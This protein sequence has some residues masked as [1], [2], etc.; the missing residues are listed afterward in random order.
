M[1]VALLM[2][3][4]LHLKSQTLKELES[5]RVSLPNGGNDPVGKM[6]PVGDLPLNMAIS[7][8]GS[9]WQSPTTVK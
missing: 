8:P 9:C 7:L 3:V 5:G 4:A 6:L 2:F 1:G